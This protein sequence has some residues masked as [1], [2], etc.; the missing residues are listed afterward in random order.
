MLSRTELRTALLLSGPVSMGGSFVAGI[1]RTVAVAIFLQRAQERHN[2]PALG[3]LKGS[4][5]RHSIGSVTVADL[6]EQ[7]AVGLALNFGGTQICC[8]VLLASP[9]LSMT[10]DTS[11][12][13][14][15][16]PGRWSGGVLGFGVGY[17]SSSGRRLP[18]VGGC[19]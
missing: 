9:F 2:I 4:E 6:P 7:C 16:S 1:P 12:H 8:T 10:V 13:K 15:L 11:T 17:G 5:R 3:F 19:M 14:S 18:L